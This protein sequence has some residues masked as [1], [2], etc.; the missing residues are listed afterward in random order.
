MLRIHGK[1]SIAIKL[2]MRE[3]ANDLSGYPF[4]T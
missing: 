3:P 2:Y 4:I 1:R